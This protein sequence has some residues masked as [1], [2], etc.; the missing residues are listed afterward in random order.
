MK[1]VAQFD[2]KKR[3]G[4]NNTHSFKLTG[5]WEHVLA[6]EAKVKRDAKHWRP[7]Q[8]G[9]VARGARGARG[10]GGGGSTPLCASELPHSDCAVMVPTSQAAIRE[11]S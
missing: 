8:G 10:A 1:K 2:A 7:L 6:K 5:L 11:R 4:T 9:I 3:E